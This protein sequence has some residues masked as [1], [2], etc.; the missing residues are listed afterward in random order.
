[1]HYTG[2]FWKHPPPQEP[3]TQHFFLDDDS[4]PELGGSRPDRLHEV[5]P[6]EQVLRHT[7]EQLG[8][9]APGLPALDVL[10]PQMVDK[11]VEVPTEPVYVLMVLASKVF[12]RRELARILSGQGSTASGSEQIVVP[13]SRR[14]RGGYLQS[15]RPGQNSTAADVEQTVDIPARGGLQGFPPGQ[16]PGR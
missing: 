2:K 1:M 15:L 5:R 4:V 9:V 16:G 12:S 13:Q 3:G 7:V 14:R 11:L 6:Q 10:V 8:D